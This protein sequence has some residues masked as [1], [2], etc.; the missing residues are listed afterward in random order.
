MRGGSPRPSE[1]VF[2][3]PGCGVVLLLALLPVFLALWFSDCGA[4][5]SCES[6]FALA[7]SSLRAFW[8]SRVIAPQGPEGS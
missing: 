3:L 6:T 1:A 7:L 5:Q 8:P 4:L 2:V